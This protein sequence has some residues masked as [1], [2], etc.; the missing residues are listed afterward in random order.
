MN[1]AIPDKKAYQTNRRRMCWAALYLALIFVHKHLLL[2]NI[3][4]LREM[5]HE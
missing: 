4:S 5:S 3:G 1:E 2:P